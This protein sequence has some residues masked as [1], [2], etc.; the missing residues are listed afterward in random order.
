MTKKT[1]TTLTVATL[2]FVGFFLLLISA[3]ITVRSQ[4]TETMQLRTT[5]AEQNAKEQVANTV[6]ITVEA[7]AND[8]AQL[9]NYFLAEK[10]TINFIADIEALAKTLGV[11]VETTSLDIIRREGVQSQLKTSFAVTGA[12]SGVVSFFEAMET[13]P[14]H[15][16]ITTVRLNREGGQVWSGSVDILITLQP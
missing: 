7:T 11:T 10:D 13:V 3:Y 2:Y 14:Y 15:S 12:R 8:R 9:Q 16:T 5:L 6:A 4:K 1:T